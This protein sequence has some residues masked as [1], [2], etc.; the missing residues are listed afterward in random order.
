MAQKKN[1]M[2]NMQIR[3]AQLLGAVL[4]M[5]VAGACSSSGWLVDD[6]RLQS[7]SI[8]LSEAADSVYNLDE[9]IMLESIRVELKGGVADSLAASAMQRVVSVFFGED[10]PEVTLAETL[11]EADI[12]FRVEEISIRRIRTLNVVHPGPVFRIRVHV[13]G[14]EGGEKVFDQRH[15]LDSNLAVKA[16][17]GARFYVPD[18]EERED[19]ELQRITIYPTLRS[20][21]GHIWQDILDVDWR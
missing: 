1:K 20:V 21:F 14:Y 10:D 9:R 18:E 2:K 6:V 15:S 11:E 16:A 12:E 17:E 13:S 3:I 7:K 19:E 4:I 5:F 8:F